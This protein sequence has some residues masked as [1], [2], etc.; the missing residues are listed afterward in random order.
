MLLPTSETV[1]KF[2]EFI[3]RRCSIRISSSRLVN[4]KTHLTERVKLKGSLSYDDYLRLLDEDSEEFD[5]LIEAITTKE[6]RFFRLPEHFKALHEKVVPE[7]EEKLSQEAQRLL[8]EGGSSRPREIPF[9]IWSAGC[10]TGEEPYS[11]AMTVMDALKYPRAWKL[12]ILATDISKSALT[13]ATRGFYEVDSIKKIPHFYQKKYL[14]LTKNGAIVTEEIAKKIRFRIFNLHDLEPTEG[15]SHLTSLDGDIESMV[16]FE[17]FH[18]VF[19]RN[20]MIYFDFS[21]QQRL[22]DK[23]YDCLKPGGY[24]FTGDAELLHIYKHKFKRVEFGN[25]CFYQKA[26][27]DE[28][29]KSKEISKE[30]IWSRE[31][32]RSKFW[33]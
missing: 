11:I 6:T 22:V 5:A 19:C 28:A 13:T 14:K 17:T 24:L 21:A 15:I 33:K 30:K 20:V 2:Q 3:Y 29:K 32:H 4:L 10:A 27:D 16:M 18:I 26:E 7:I 12:E 25:A 9:K 1:H 23:L 31:P 8:G